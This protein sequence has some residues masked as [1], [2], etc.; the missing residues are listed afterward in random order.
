MSD[1]AFQAKAS[2]MASAPARLTLT[3]LKRETLASAPA[4][5]H[6]RAEQQPM[7]RNGGLPSPALFDTSRQRPRLYP[8]PESESKSAEIGS[9]AHLVIKQQGA[10]A[11]D[12]KSM[13]GRARSAGEPAAS[14]S[15]GSAANATYVLLQ[16][17]AELIVSHAKRAS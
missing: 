10:A 6:H 11:G 2:C 16:V 7:M 13:S 12:T 3:A 9:N 4:R 5:R 8:Q 15:S 14:N 1:L 17:S